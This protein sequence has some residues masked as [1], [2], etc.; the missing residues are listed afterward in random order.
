MTVVGSSNSVHKVHLPSQMSFIFTSFLSPA[1]SKASSAN[2]PDTILSLPCV[3]YLSLLNPPYSQNYHLKVQRALQRPNLKVAY[4]AP[5]TTLS[6]SSFASAVA[7][8]KTSTLLLLT[9]DLNSTTASFPSNPSNPV[10]QPATA[11]PTTRITFTVSMPFPWGSEGKDNTRPHIGA[12]HGLFQLEPTLQVLRPIRPWSLS[13]DMLSLDNAAEKGVLRFGKKGESG[14]ALDFNQGLATLRSLSSKAEDASML[15][16]SR[17]EEVDGYRDI[18][19]VAKEDGWETS[20]RIR[21]LDLYVMEVESP[22]LAEE[23]DQKKQDELRTIEAHRLAELDRVAR[24]AGP[25]VSE[26]ELRKRI[27]GIGRSQESQAHDKEMRRLATPQEARDKVSK[28]ELGK[29]IQ[30]FGSSG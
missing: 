12:S 5:S 3:Q 10:K 13:A 26:E 29:R 15:G 16:A 17:S 6:A 1:P 20:M 9:G 7:P 18:G 24:E 25:K 22:P 8:I 30:G 27:Q 14:L 2:R 4:S 19:L 11:H 28:K 23:V 21:S